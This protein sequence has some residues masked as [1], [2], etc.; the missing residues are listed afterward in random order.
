VQTWSSKAD[1]FIQLAR[2]LYEA[3]ASTSTCSV[4]Q[5]ALGLSTEPAQA[6]PALAHVAVERARAAYVEGLSWSTSENGDDLPGLLCNWGTGLLAAGE[7][8]AGTGRGEEAVEL[9]RDAVSRLSASLDF[10]RGDIQVRGLAVLC[11]RCL[12]Q[13]WLA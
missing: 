8:A 1:A 2:T 6:A 12:V 3:P 5:H 11:E 9:L 13:T 4:A 7:L 10:D